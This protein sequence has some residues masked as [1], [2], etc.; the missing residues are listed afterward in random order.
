MHKQA[1]LLSLKKAS[2]LYFGSLLYLFFFLIPAET[3]VQD[4]LHAPNL[5]KLQ[6]HI[7]NRRASSFQKTLCEKQL[8]LKTIPHACYLFPAL[9]NTADFH[10]LSLKI[11][12]ITLSSLKKALVTPLSSSCRKS[13]KNFEKIL[14]YRKK[15]LFLN[16][17]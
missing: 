7:Q 5:Q 17:S 8:L 10:C 3:K 15:D 12:D 16:K 9:K 14:L 6:I 11:G 2:C 4:I 13:L 1:Q